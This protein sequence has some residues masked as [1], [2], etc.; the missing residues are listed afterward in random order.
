MKIFALL[1]AATLV[2]PGCTSHLITLQ[3]EIVASGDGKA[4]VFPGVYF[5]KNR[6]AVRTP[7]IA[8]LVPVESAE[9]VAK[10]F[11]GSS[12]TAE[13]S[14]ETT[15]RGVFR[16]DLRASSAVDSVEVDVRFHSYPGPASPLTQTIRVKPEDLEPPP[17]ADSGPDGPWFVIVLD[18]Y[19][20]R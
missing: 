1:V 6:E 20:R 13:G 15:A 2:L 17:G 10:C 8:T 3:G 9:I 14:S 19:N 11:S 7:G 12:F 18:R 4:D 16:I 5:G